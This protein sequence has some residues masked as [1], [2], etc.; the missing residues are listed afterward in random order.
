MCIRDR[1]VVEALHDM[2]RSRSFY[3]SFLASLSYLALQLVPI[4]ALMM[5]YGLDLPFRAAMV[6]L[7]ILRLGTLLPQAPGNVGSFQFFTVV[8][9]R[10]FGVDK[11]DATGF[12]TLLF[13]VVTVPLWLA[14]FVATLTSGLGF[15]EIRRRATETSRRG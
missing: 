3:Y 11:S 14:G 9:L 6:T 5:G 13:L 2:G 12:A 4:Y 10:L 7:V 15:G 8:A 1:H